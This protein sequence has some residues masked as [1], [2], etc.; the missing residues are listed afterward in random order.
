M[1]P[2]Q[3]GRQALGQGRRVA[4][5]D[6]QPPRDGGQ[7]QGGVA[8]RR[9]IDEDD[10]VGEGVRRAL[11]RLDRQPRL[12]HAAGSGQGAQ[13]GLAASQHV[14]HRRRRAGAPNQGR[15]R[16]RQGARRT[17]WESRRGGGGAVGAGRLQETGA[18]LRVQR[19]RIG[20]E[21]HAVEPRRA[22]WVALQVTDGLG[23]Q[24]GA[25]RQRLLSQA[26]RQAQPPQ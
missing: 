17:R 18:S 23:A 22:G 25:L 19:Q 26:G 12:A 8:E 10:A 13:L 7:H 3:G 24:A 11:G 21:G 9:Q 15:E 20:Q 2:A 5:V 6:A 14:R 1:L 16:P 4:L